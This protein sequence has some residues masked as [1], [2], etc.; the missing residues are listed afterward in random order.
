MAF[1]KSKSLACSQQFATGSHPERVDKSMPSQ[2]NI[3]INFNIILLFP[4]N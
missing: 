3:K 2:P 1:V 4:S